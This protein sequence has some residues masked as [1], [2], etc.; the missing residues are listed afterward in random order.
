MRDQ[1]QKPTYMRELK[2]KVYSV[3]LPSSGGYYINATLTFTDYPTLERFLKDAVNGV[4]LNEYDLKEGKAQFIVEV[5]F[6][7]I[8][9]PEEKENDDEEEL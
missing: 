3:Q 1:K 8:L 6:D 5:Q 2:N 7:P 4:A 9:P